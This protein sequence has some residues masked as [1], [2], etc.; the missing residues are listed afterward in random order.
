MIVRIMAEG[1]YR[2]SDDVRERVNELDNSVV[3]AVE[4]NDEDAFH[5]AFEELLDVIRSEGEH[6][7]D[8]EL[9]T[10]DVIIPPADTSMAEA[11]ADFSGEGL[12]PD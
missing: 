7:G 12:I 9:E 8:D 11:T 1:Q 10:S 4:G 3:A 2:L 6:V 5:A